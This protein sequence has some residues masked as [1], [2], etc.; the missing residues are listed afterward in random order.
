MAVCMATCMATC[1]WLRLC[2]WAH[3]HGYVHGHGYGHGCM[4]MHMA[5]ATATGMHA[6]G[7]SYNQQQVIMG[8]AH[9]YIIQTSWYSSTNISWKL[10]NYNIITWYYNGKYA[11]TNLFR[12]S[13]MS[14]DM[15]ISMGAWV[16]GCTVNSSGRVHQHQ[17]QS[18]PKALALLVSSTAQVHHSTDCPV[19]VPL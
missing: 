8:L 3:V 7:L 10:S 17:H 14:I 1:A 2:A 12:L 18:L 13:G 11:W 16:H 6:H 19:H 4:R 9:F 15:S 5:T